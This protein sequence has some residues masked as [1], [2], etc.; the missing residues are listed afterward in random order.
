M[1][2]KLLVLKAIFLFFYQTSYLNEEVKCTKP[3]T[4][5]RVPCGNSEKLNFL[6]EFGILFSLMFVAKATSQQIKP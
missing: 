3:Y 6:I 4:S 1:D 5:V 2:Q